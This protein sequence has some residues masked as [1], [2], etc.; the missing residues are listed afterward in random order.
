MPGT[1]VLPAGPVRNRGWFF[2]SSFVFA[3]LMIAVSLY[4]R[5]RLL[6]VPLERDEGGFAYIAQ[7]LLRGVPPFVSG[8][9]KS[10]PGV[11]VAYA[12]ILAIFGESA[13]GIH[14]GL[15]V[16][17]LVSTVLIFLLAR[18]LMSVE[19]AAVAAGTFSYL[20]VSQGVLGVFAHATHFVALFVLAGVVLLLKGL[21][22]QR[23]AFLFLAGL[24]FGVAVEMKQHAVFFC[25]NACLL[26]AGQGRV[27]GGWR[28]TLQRL[29]YILIGMIVPYAANCLYM[30][31][32]GVFREFWFWTFTYSLTY[33]SDNTLHGAWTNVARA[34]S[35]LLK[36]F[37]PALLFVPIG[38]LASLT[39]KGPQRSNG[40]F[41]L[42]FTLFSSAAVTPGL[43]FYQ[44]YF[45]MLLPA[46][47]LLAGLGS[48][49]LADGI[50]KLSVPA[51]NWRQGV[52][53][54]VLLLTGAVAIAR[55]R[56]YLFTLSPV[57]VSRTI[58]GLN[59]F[60][61]SIEVARFIKNE[62]DPSATIGVIGSEPQICFYAE[63]ASATDYLYMY[64]LCSPHPNVRQMQNEMIKEIEAARPEFL[65]F[66]A[67]E[68][69]WL[70]RGEGQRIIEW[71]QEY[72]AAY[73]QVGLVEITGAEGSI[74]KWGKEAEVSKVD[75]N[76]FLVIYRRVET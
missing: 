33:A 23:L 55:E 31:W 75:E 58:Y 70:Y 17:N 45:V 73:R 15:L 28:S 8:N 24:C 60:P 1:E 66:V 3:A 43:L 34:L 41:L 68:T 62:S 10:L 56:E 74:Y 46:L 29:T 32:H 13:T 59:P 49:V 76:P 69:S 51:L 65:V 38:F 47:S 21:K 57:A 7:Q 40:R 19:G 2:Y 61:E 6:P 44:H 50:A 27:A 30:A 39:Q 18:R 22:D 25:L 26:I 11:E 37:A 14:A 64:G 52:L 48:V 67:V 63:R 72:L 35:D 12:C 36:Y 54:V 42:Y 9:M 53:P 16:V 4:T 71:L 20:S 5:L